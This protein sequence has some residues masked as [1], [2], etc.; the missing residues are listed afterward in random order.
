MTELDNSKLFEHLEKRKEVYSTSSEDDDYDDYYEIDEE[1]YE[2]DRQKDLRKELHANEV[3]DSSFEV[4][5]TSSRFS[6]FKRLGQFFNFSTPEQKSLYHTTV[7][8]IEN[9]LLD[10]VLELISNGFVMSSKMNK[11]FHEQFRIY[12]KSQPFSQIEALLKKQIKISDELI[13]LLGIYSKD[14]MLLNLTP[15]HPEQDKINHLFKLDRFDLMR[16]EN[17]RQK[18]PY[19][20]QLYQ[21]KFQDK[22]FQQFVFS[23]WK[24]AIENLITTHPK[25]YFSIGDKTRYSEIYIIQNLHF[26]IVSSFGNANT[27][28]F[29]LFSEMKMND[30]LKMMSDIK[31]YM[32][33]NDFF[34]KKQLKTSY[35]HSA[36][37]INYAVD[38]ILSETYDKMK[39]QSDLLYSEDFQSLSNTSIPLV[40]QTLT[41]LNQPYNPKKNVELP[42]IAKKIIQSIQQSYQFIQYNDQIL[43][44]NHRQDVQRLVNQRI[45][46]ILETYFKI[47]HSTIPTEK[48]P[49]ELLLNS[50]GNIE[51]TLMTIA[52]NLNEKNMS[53]LSVSHRYTEE[54]KLQYTNEANPIHV[55][56]NISTEQKNIIDEK[57]INST[58]EKKLTVRQ[59]MKKN[60]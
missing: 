1:M 58:T 49:D 31:D 33:K 30:Y 22:K 27:G 59:I 28:F 57:E 36:F 6:W 37:A 56:D 18:Y 55:D 17:F 46:E 25:K 60:I 51:M 53:L 50:L 45:P 38:H 54:F 44:E 12:A 35:G 52:K 42:P 29:S 40:H 32:N 48:N 41:E 26:A 21:N 10:K 47:I 5:L 13:L 8:L 11:K 39:L 7:H 20:T 24:K 14:V 16:V 3:V 9:N 34:V 15:S 4:K 43:D 2:Y 19:L 23:S